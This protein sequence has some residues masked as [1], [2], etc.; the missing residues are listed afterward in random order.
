VAIGYCRECDSKVSTSA[1]FCPHCGVNSPTASD[2]LAALSPS[3]SNDKR[4]PVAVRARR[5]NEGVLAGV[6]A[7]VFGAL[8]IF[9]LGIIFVP[10]AALC[11]AIGLLLALAGRSSS[12]FVTSMIG[13]VLTAIGFVFSPTLW[14]LVGG[15]LVSA[16]DHQSNAA[17]N[18]TDAINGTP[19]TKPSADATKIEFVAG[20][21]ATQPN[22]NA[23]SARLS[24]PQLFEGLWAQTKEECLDEDGPNSRTL[25]DLGNV[26]DGKPT[27]IFDQYE[28]H[29]RIE[30]KTAFGDGT[31]LTVTCFE[32]GEE[33]TNNSGGRKA[34]I[35]LSPKREGGLAID[36]K[37]Y[38]RCETQPSPTNAAADV[39]ANT[40]SRAASIGPGAS[41]ET[42]EQDKAWTEQINSG[43][44]TRLRDRRTDS[45][46][47][48]ADCKRLHSQEPLCISYEGFA[49][50]WFDMANDSNPYT[51]KL[52]WT[53]NVIN[54]LGT[55]T[56]DSDD[57]EY[58]QS[59]QYRQMLHKLSRVIFSPKRNQWKNKKEVGDFAYKICMEGHPF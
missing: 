36:G 14:L 49:S 52:D 18:K 57:P 20:S 45:P 27:P 40:P 25:I 35:K 46:V 43:P 50:V 3:T 53:T 8:G 44:C 33:F 55:K 7:C 54:S 19:A 59:P 2:P 34:T 41:S 9:T 42:Y 37:T 24:A 38:Q 31:A 26:V 51:N 30:R 56:I 39:R 5:R 4:R 21:K 10:L 23:T 6:F 47:D 1:K 15:L 16:Q 48:I 58:Y 12:G 17:T 11:S 13:G 32:F 29:C 28:N 22:Q